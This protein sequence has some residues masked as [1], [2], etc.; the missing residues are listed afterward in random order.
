[1]TVT[2]ERRT[3]PTLQTRRRQVWR[4]TRHYLEMVAAMV[5]GMVTLYP[6]WLLA[7]G[8]AADDSWVHGTEPELLAMATA[9][10]VPMVLWMWHRGHR[11]RPT[12]EMA[13][14]MYAGFV[15]LFPFLWAGALDEMDVMM[16][17]HVLM[18]LFMLAAMLWRREEYVG[19]C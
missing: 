11:A 5:L 2:L 8:G 14:A 4:F 6:F 13:V 7:T 19:H 15:A 17:G 3:R 16:S 18:P 10:T 9:M 1:M 12:A